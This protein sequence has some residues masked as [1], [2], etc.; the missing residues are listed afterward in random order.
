LPYVTHYPRI[1]M[2]GL[3]SNKKT[4]VKMTGLHA[5]I[6]KRD[7]QYMKQ[8]SNPLDNDVRPQICDVKRLLH[9]KLNI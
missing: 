7:L 8:E 5:K 1:S 2:E 6:L 9:N 3:K 4:S